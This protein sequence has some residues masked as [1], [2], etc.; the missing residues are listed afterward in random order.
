MNMKISKVL[1]LSV[2]TVTIFF[3]LV[4][5]QQEQAPKAEIEVINPWLRDLPKGSMNSAGFMTI[6]NNTDKP[7]ILEGV[8]LD[9]ARHA[10]LHESKIID[11][12][13]K[14]SHQDELIIEKR[15]EFKPGGLH[16]MIMGLNAP[17]NE[18][19]AYNILLHFKQRD[20]LVVSFK[21]GQTED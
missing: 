13:A 6:V 10:M 2:L 16:I 8:S 9:W 7:F 11:G 3:I 21:V 20:P 14:M 17:L 12:M 1:I 19:K 5:C 4:A 18:D 15:I